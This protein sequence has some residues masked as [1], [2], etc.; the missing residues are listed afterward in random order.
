MRWATTTTAVKPASSPSSAARFPDEA[1]KK[2]RQQ[3]ERAELG[4]RTRGHDHLAEHRVGVL[5]IP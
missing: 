2:H 3:A 4:Q 1:E 5:G